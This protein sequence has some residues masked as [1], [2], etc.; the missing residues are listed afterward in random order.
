MRNAEVAEHWLG[1]IHDDALAICPSVRLE[2]LVSARTSSDYD[3]LRRDLEALP[4]LPLD[5]E[6]VRR[7]ENVQGALARS[8]HHR[9]ATPVDLLIAA[10]AE[11]HDVTLVHYDRHFDTI[12][13][14]TGQPTRWI[15][16][17]GTL[18]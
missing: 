16:P 18:D 8:G 3:E 2:L 17:R 12:A 11:A 14:L 9:G 15:A 1:W 6:I 7:A 5:A 4:E 10:T 13:A